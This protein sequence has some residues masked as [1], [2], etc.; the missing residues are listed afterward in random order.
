M[1]EN[2]HVGLG[3]GGELL[4]D[5]L[6]TGADGVSTGGSMAKNFGFVQL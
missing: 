1:D 3:D 4:G 6:L 5:A 2:G